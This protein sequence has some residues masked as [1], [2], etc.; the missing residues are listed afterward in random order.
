MNIKRTLPLL[1]LAICAC[2]RIPVPADAPEMGLTTFTISDGARELTKVTSVT[3]ETNT[4]N[5]Q[6][7]VYSPAGQLCASGTLSSGSLQLSVPIG[8]AGHTVVAFVN[9]SID[10]PSKTKL[11]DIDSYTSTLHSNADGGKNALEM[12]GK[13]TNVSFTSGGSCQVTVTRYAAK[14][15]IDKITNN[16]PSKPS[17]SVTGIYLINVNTLCKLDGT[18]DSYSWSQKRS[19]VSSESQVIKYTADI[20]TEAVSYGKSY[21]TPHYFYCYP[22][23]TT[24][25]TSSSTWSARYTRLVV[26]ASYAGTTCYYPI[27]IKS[28][29]NKLH[30]NALYKITDL[31]ITGPGSSDPD[32]PFSKANATFT[33]TIKDWDTGF[34]QTVSY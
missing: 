3:G 18:V 30:G 16:I 22:N 7:A 8:I 17:F 24:T 6:I 23:S 11:S 27:N 9:S 31:T 34:T 32:V 4:D 5:V 21:E 33:I 26:Q 20:F 2:T 28:S 14:V 13:K 15:E 12:Y 25:D 10:L 1:L 29:D 19:Y